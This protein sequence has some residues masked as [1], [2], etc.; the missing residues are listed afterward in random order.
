[1]TLSRTTKSSK[2]LHYAAPAIPLS[3][4]LMP[5]I[6]YIPPFYA[7]EMHLSMTVVGVIFFFARLWDAVIDPLVG[8]L[9]D[10][11]RS[12]WGRRKPWIAFGVIPL[13]VSAYLLFQPPKTVGPAYLLIVIF[14]FYLAWTIVQ[15]PYLSWGA[16]ISDD[17]RERNRVVGFREGGTMVGI[18]LVTGVPAL[19]FY[20]QVP[21]LRQ[22]LGVFFVLTVIL[23][24]LTTLIALWRVPDTS[25]ENFEKTSILKAVRILSTN[26]PFLRLIF[27]TFIIWLAVYIYNAGI[28]FVLEKSLQFSGNNF[29]RVVF[30]QFLIGTI[31]T[32]AIVKLAGKFGKHVVLAGAAVLT[33]VAFTALSHARPGN[34]TDV[35]LFFS[36]LG[37]TISPIWVLPTALVA[38]AADLGELLGGGK[39]EGLYMAIYN[40][41]MKIA[42]AASVGIALP[43][44]SYLGFNPSQ[45]VTSNGTQALHMVALYLPT[46]LLLLGALVMVRY[47]VDA[48]AHAAIRLDLDEH[49]QRLGI[50]K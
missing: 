1:M 13:L 25:G 44:L 21:T 49:R 3:M 9:S 43:L 22:I 27:G 2:L 32:P 45:P 12:H 50:S 42:I 6:M 5:P 7:I 37:L 19:V 28:F 40:L 34:T 41:A 8:S 16:E 36:V 17:Y 15:I 38:D 14:F 26:K 35:V 11:T 10:Q 47:P 30:L 18:L 29:L 31:A 48:K 39:K 4:L 33:A 24:P 46:A 20:N 23:L